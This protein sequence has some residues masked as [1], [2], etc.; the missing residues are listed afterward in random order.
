MYHK[1]KKVAIVDDAPFIREVLRNIAISQGWHVVGEAA[2]GFEATQMAIACKPD[3]ILMDIVMPNVNGIDAAKYILRN[4]TQIKIIA[5]STVDQENVLLKAIEAGCCSY[6]TKPFN[7]E[8]VIKVVNQ[9]FE[10]IKEVS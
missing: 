9:A 8:E 7:R 10:L 6:I 2:D 1:I 4:N 5:C 3:L